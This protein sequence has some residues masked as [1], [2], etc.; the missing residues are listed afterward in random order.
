MLNPKIKN[1]ETC[2]RIPTTAG[3]SDFANL[4]R[5]QPRNDR[6]DILDL[7]RN[8]GKPEFERTFDWHYSASATPSTSWCLRD[9]DSGRLS[10]FISVLERHFNLGHTRI[11]AAVAAD[12]LIA[13]SSRS[14][15]A[16]LSLIRATPI[17]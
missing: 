2:G 15:G 16:A 9:Q 11:R 13:E 17:L 8:N 12:L 10:G 5:I 3:R 6:S 1:A 4:E 7:F 14:L